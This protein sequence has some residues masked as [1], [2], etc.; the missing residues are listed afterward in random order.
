MATTI[1]P[2]KK[3]TFTVARVPD[4]VACQKTIRRLM[5]MQPHVQNGLKKLSKRREREDNETYVRAG[6]EWTNRAR[7]T[8][9]TH[10]APGETFTIH[11]SAH[12]LPDIR[13]VEPF[14]DASVA[15]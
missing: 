7:T 13:S 2:G 5:R 4:R 1:E 11:V 15:G 14:L 6:R 3:Y 8:K 12:I 9:L 10:I